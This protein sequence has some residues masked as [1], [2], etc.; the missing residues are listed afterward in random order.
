MSSP[1][2]LKKPA[3]IVVFE[4]PSFSWNGR[5]KGGHASAPETSDLAAARPEHPLAALWLPDEK[6]QD[7][8]VF[9]FSCGGHEI[10]FFRAE[11]RVR[12][13][14]GVSWSRSV[15]RRRSR[16]SRSMAVKS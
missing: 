5:G 14:R 15:P 16:T 6:R 3:L 7:Q 8:L 1:L 12:A 10:C 9:M 11:R 4:L 13:S 2:L